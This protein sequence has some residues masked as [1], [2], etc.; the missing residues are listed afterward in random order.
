M[1]RKTNFFRSYFEQNLKWIFYPTKKLSKKS[2]PQ[3]GDVKNI[4]QKSY[5]KKI[6]Q[7]NT[8]LYHINDFIAKKK[9]ILQY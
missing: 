6:I 7:I 3:V 8:I 4:I 1:V 9:G 5:P 2:Y